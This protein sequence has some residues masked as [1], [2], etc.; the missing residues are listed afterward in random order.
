MAVMDKD[1]ANKASQDKSQDKKNT[2]NQRKNASQEPS[3]DD[4]TSVQGIAKHSFDSSYAVVD[5]VIR[6][7]SKAGVEKAIADYRS[8]VEN[9]ERSFKEDFL[10]IIS[11]ES[12]TQSYEIGESVMR[13]LTQSGADDS[14]DLLAIEGTSDNDQLLEVVEIINA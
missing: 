14:T 8:Q 7:S 3:Q 10:Q 5:R 2:S 6:Q 13:L 1:A 12:E 4:L 9:F 11:A